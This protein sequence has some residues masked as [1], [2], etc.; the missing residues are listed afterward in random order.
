MADYKPHPFV[1]P[2]HRADCTDFYRDPTEDQPIK[3]QGPLAVLHALEL[4]SVQA[5]RTFNAQLLYMID[6]CLGDR[7]VS[8]DDDRDA[9]SW[10]AMFAQFEMWVDARAE[11]VPCT[12]FLKHTCET[13][14]FS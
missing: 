1:T 3:L 6:V 13:P 4:A 8:A 9:R 2:L 12:A 14:R 11:W 10:R 7:A 5:G